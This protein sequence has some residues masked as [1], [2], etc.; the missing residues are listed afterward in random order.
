MKPTSAIKRVENIESVHSKKRE[1]S[2]Y[3]Y[4][5]HCKMH[6]SAKHQKTKKSA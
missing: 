3:M 5:E 1:I 4:P 2:K 6:I